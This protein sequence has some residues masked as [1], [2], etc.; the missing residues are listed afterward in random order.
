MRS[1]GG[2][3]RAVLNPSGL[4]DLNKQHSLIHI[5]EPDR[6]P[7]HRKQGLE[8]LEEMNMHCLHLT[9]WLV[10]TI[11]APLKKPKSTDFSS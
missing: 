9:N 4:L 1:G 3:G 10:G 2:G 6:S 7:L 11:S 8:H 5:S